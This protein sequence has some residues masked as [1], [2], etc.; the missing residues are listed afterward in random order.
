MHFFPGI[1]WFPWYCFCVMKLWGDKAP[2]TNQWGHE[3]S[4][5]HMALLSELERYHI[6]LHRLFWN[7]LPWA[8]HL[9]SLCS[10]FLIH[11][12]KTPIWICLAGLIPI[13]TYLSYSCLWQIENW[14]NTKFY[15]Y[16]S[17]YLCRNETNLAQRNILKADQDDSSSVS[18]SVRCRW[19]SAEKI[20]YY[21]N[22][23][24]LNYLPVKRFVMIN[25]SIE[26]K[27]DKTV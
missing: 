24:V 21:L 26:K 2:V 4:N 13:P 6:S 27:K 20:K 1:P 8:N 16:Y 5:T 17:T 14:G 18:V 10:Y 22:Y 15:Y 9:T 25:L 23:K 19:Y 12:T 7:Q 11:K 3:P